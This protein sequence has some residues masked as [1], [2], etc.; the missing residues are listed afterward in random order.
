MK[1]L[2]RYIGQAVLVTSVFAIGVLSLV[3][4]LG[5]IFKRLLDLLVN[6][7]VPL[8]FIFSF[9]AYVLPFSLSFTIPWG[10]L[11]AILLIFGKL[12]AENE[13]TAMRATGISIPRIALPVL[14]LSVLLS[15]VCYYINVNV[16]PKAQLKMRTAI[17]E[18]ATSNPIALFGSDQVIEEFPGRK[19]Y[20]GEKNGNELTNIFIYEIDDNNV[21]Q[22]VTFAHKGR[23][24]T[25]PGKSS[26]G[27]DAVPEV[28]MTLFDA[29]FE[30]V[31]ETMPRHVNRMRHGITM[32]RGVLSI[33]LEELY[34]KNQK[35]RGLSSMTME[36][37]SAKLE[38]QADS[39]AATATRTEMNK[40]VS[41]SL[42]CIAFALI[43]VPFGITA[44]RRETMVGFVFSLIIAFVY[45]LFII[46]ADTFRNNPAAYPHYL[47][48]IPNVLFGALGL[49]LFWRLSRK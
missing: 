29:R 8:E 42:A 17:Y 9:I 14:I 4:V 7:D 21:P 32:D 33:S 40:R 2:D 38:P 1:I 5:N 28:R 11:T 34:E 39:A 12:S 47:V 18:M 45:F 41:F 35:R 43:A 3:L 31:D 27:D 30:Q 19:I 20:V 22:R 6:H 16:A 36:E 46:L 24:D 23:L 49:V 48:W 15:L 44:Q 26:N 10:F 13:L 25:H 37:L